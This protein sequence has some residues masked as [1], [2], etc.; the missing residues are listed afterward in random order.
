MLHAD[1][2]TDRHGDANRLILTT[3]VANLP[4]TFT[5]STFANIYCTWGKCFTTDTEYR[6]RDN[7][8]SLERLF[9]FP[10][11]YTEIQHFMEHTC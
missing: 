10:P 6:G 1:R 2:Q 11:N 3:S 8:V 9:H 4:R 7:T 5:A